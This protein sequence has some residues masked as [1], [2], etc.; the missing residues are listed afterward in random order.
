VSFSLGF[1]EI[2]L[3]NGFVYQDEMNEKQASFH[4]CADKFRWM[5][6][7]VGGGKS[8][9]ALVEALR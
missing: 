5:G 9:A 1:P 8:V 2:T 4:T 7:G 6:G 3:D